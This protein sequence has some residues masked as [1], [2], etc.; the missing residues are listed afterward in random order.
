[1]LGAVAGDIIGSVHEGAGTKTKDFPL[2]DEDSRFTDGTVLTAAV[3]DKLLHGGN[4]VDLFHQW[5]VLP[6]ELRMPS[7]AVSPKNSPGV[8]SSDWMTHCVAFCWNSP[9]A[10]VR[11]TE[12]G[13]RQRT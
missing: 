11:R 1:M 9:I 13:R 3:A 4:Y 5:P 10:F 2:W 6:V 12:S 7:M 8:R